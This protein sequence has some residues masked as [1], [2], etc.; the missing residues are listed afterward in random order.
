MKLSDIVNYKLSI[1]NVD[2]KSVQHEY[3]KFKKNLSSTLDTHDV[4]FGDIKSQIHSD[5]QNI[6]NLFE[7][8]ET[9]LRLF[10]QKLD[11]FIHTYEPKYYEMGQSVYQDTVNDSAEYIF[12]RHTNQGLFDTEEDTQF[13]SADF[14]CTQTGDTQECT[15][16]HL[17]AGYLMCLKHWILCILS[18]LIQN[19]CKKSN[20]FGILN[21]K[22]V[23]GITHR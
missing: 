9:N 22:N 12:E 8:V 23:C 19:C 6:S 15:S 14:L 10:E 20:N 7:N 1:R 16:D 17:M 5:L 18:I 11:A 13:L 3:Y 2:T 21:I 4:D